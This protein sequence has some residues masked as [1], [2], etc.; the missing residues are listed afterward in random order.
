VA[1]VKLTA[2]CDQRC[3]FCK[4]PEDAGNRVSV[5]EALGL[6]PRLAERSRLLTLSGGE[7]TLVTELPAVVSC[8]RAAGFRRVELQTNGMAL[9]DPPRMAELTEAGLTNVLVSLHADGPDL[10]DELTGTPGGFG[11]TLTGIDRALEAGIQV[12]ICHVICDGNVVRLDA[13]ADFIR[14]RFRGHALQ[15]VFTAAIPT[16]RVRREPGLMPD[17]E[18]AGPALQAALARFAPARAPWTTRPGPLG[19]VLTTGRR[20]LEERGPR[21]RAW[22]RRLRHLTT[23]PERW[24]RGHRARVIAHCGLPVCVLGERAVYH[25]E[26]WWTQPAPATAEL[27]HP[28]AC[29]PCIR[30]SRCSGLWRV[31]LERFGDGAVVPL[32]GAEGRALRP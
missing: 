11:R 17:L 19:R 18:V 10:S 7:A 16:Y 9:A 6:L 13:F 25:D 27:A 12:S 32:T 3:V 29:D 30:R 26:W 23:P 31:Y 2:R 20:A 5:G 15:V 21:G 1:E 24:R 22:V 14:D 4:S 28:A 8:A